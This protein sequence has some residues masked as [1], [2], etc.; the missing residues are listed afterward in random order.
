MAER[1]EGHEF[2]GSVP[3][4]ASLYGL[5]AGILQSAEG[6]PRQI[7]PKVNAGREYQ[8]LLVSNQ[9]SSRKSRLSI[10]P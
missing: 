9:L 7:Q 1:I 8:R 6:R 3:R 4:W 2:C 5:I 10:V